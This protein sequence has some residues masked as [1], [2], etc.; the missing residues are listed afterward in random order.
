M[1]CVV[2]NSQHITKQFKLRNT[3]IRG[4]QVDW[5]IFDQRDL[6]HT[7]N[8]IF[9]TGVVRNFGFDSLENPYKFNFSA[10]EPEESKGSAFEIA[11]KNSILGPREI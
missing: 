4:I 8:D 7:D 10:I 5:K 9:V 2:T 11:P 3:G 6:D 1:P